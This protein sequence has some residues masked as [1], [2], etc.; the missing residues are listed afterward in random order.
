MAMALGLLLA[1]GAF[2]PTLLLAA[3]PVDAHASTVVEVDVGG[4]ALTLDV[5]EAPLAELLRT[6][7]TKA[8]IG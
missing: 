3:E 1:A 8:G 6:I 2:A 5:R 7:A 4:D